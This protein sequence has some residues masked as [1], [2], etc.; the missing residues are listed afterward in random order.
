LEKGFLADAMRA[1]AFETE[2]LR[3]LSEDDVTA[4]VFRVGGEEFDP[5]GADAGSIAFSGGGLLFPNILAKKPP[6]PV[7]I[8]ARLFPASFTLQGNLGADRKSIVPEIPPYPNILM[9]PICLWNWT[10]GWL[11]VRRLFDCSAS[12]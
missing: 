3:F 12:K 9:A 2:L 4:A 7:L 8:N 11:R 1:E 5:P 10:L 6:A